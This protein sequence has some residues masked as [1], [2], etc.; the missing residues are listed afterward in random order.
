MVYYLVIHR[1]QWI[2]P[3][4]LGSESCDSRI[5]YAVARESIQI[6]SLD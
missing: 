2:K 6:H 3:V 5:R 1:W 4:Y